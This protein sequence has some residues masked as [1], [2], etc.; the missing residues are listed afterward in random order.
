M[1]EYQQSLRD[2]LQRNHLSYSWLINMMKL[3][4][5]ETDKATVSSAVNGTITGDRVTKINDLGHAILDQ[6]E[7]EFLSSLKP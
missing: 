7:R 1:G 2:R 5:F 6:Y 4:G 3:R